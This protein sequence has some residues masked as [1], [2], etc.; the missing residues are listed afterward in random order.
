MLGK[1]GG[2]KADSANQDPASPCLP[3]EHNYL[4]ASEPFMTTRER[5]TALLVGSK[6]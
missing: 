5:N 6:R 4:G 1:A 2:R 3:R